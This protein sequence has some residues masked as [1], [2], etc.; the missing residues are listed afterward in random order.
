MSVAKIAVPILATAMLLLAGCSDQ[1]AADA[2]R[3]TSESFEFGQPA[4]SRDSDRVIQI[5]ASD[6]FRFDPKAMDVMIGEVITFT[7]TNVGEVPHE[8]TL[9]PADVQAQHGEEMTE[10]G[11]IEMDDDPNSISISAG[12]TNS[13]TWEFTEAG[14]LLF[15]CH[16]PGHYEAG[17]VGD[18]EVAVA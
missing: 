2:S 15:G 6:D 16:V 8:F 12:E 18:L 4:K 1:D 17:M 9:G 10:M 11:D 3:Q 5:D 14:S 7:V 13:L